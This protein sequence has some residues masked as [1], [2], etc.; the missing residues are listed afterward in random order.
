MRLFKKV[1]STPLTALVSVAVGAF[2][3][4]SNTWAHSDA[5]D[6]EFCKDGEIVSLATITIPDMSLTVLSQNSKVDCPVGIAEPIGRII[7][8]EGKEDL[9]RYVGETIQHRN[10]YASRHDFFDDTDAKTAYS[11]A[12]CQCASLINQDINMNEVRPLLLSPESLLSET[13]HE[14]YQLTD[15]IT[16]SCNVCKK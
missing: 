7:L 8:N 9:H 10:Q 1:N 5:S 2:I 12:A 6:P 4:S 13:H 16:F 11:M 15:G 14:S 3:F